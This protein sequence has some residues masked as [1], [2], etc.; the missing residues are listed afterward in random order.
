M[1][2]LWDILYIYVTLP[3]RINSLWP[4][5]AIWI[6]ISWPTLVQ[7]MA[8]HPFGAKT[9]SQP[10]LTYCQF[11]PEKHI[12][13]KFYLILKTFSFKQIHSGK[14]CAKCQPFCWGPNDHVFNQIFHYTDHFSYSKKNLTIYLAT[15]VLIH[16]RHEQQLDTTRTKFVFFISNKARGNMITYCVQQDKEVLKVLTFCQ[17]GESFN[18]STTS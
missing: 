8:C 7:L 5:N 3:R 11:Y 4:R 16:G 1:H 10:M 17:F 2:I 14:L 18:E 15:W 6:Q 9:S 13:R 12:S